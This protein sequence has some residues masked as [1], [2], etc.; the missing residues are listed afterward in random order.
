[1]YLAAHHPLVLRE[2]SQARSRH[3][4]QRV[5][6]SLP[7]CVIMVM[8]GRSNHGVA[9][10]DGGETK[11]LMHLECIEKIVRKKIAQPASSTY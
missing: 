6:A 10:I 8:V 5:R 11:R 3:A 1:M 9:Y 7:L 2:L 4:I